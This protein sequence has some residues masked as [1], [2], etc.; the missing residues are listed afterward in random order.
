MVGLQALE[1]V[2]CVPD[3]RRAEFEAA[4]RREG[5][6]D[7]QITEQDP[8]GHLVRAERRDQYFPVCYV[9]PL[10]GNR[11]LLG[12]DLASDSRRQAAFERA[13][14]LRT[15]IAT[16]PL[17]P[18]QAADR[19]FVFLVVLPV[20]GSGE[21]TTTGYPPPQFRGFV[22]GVFHPDT[23]IED[24]LKSLKPIGINIDVCQS[25]VP[26]SQHLAYRHRSRTLRGPDTAA[27]AEDVDRPQG[28]FSVA[29]LAVGQQSWSLLMKPTPA[30]IAARTTWRPWNVLGGGLSSPCCW[31]LTSSQ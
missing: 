20:Y 15:I 24:A 4:V 11:P 31:P 14:R 28:I 19:R 5:F 23:M 7:F 16:T 12:Y 29:S 18:V 1:W 27:S 13:R 6:R 10:G 8:R 21:Q 30:F 26:S 25:P 17:N 3:S 2:P 9:E 22:L